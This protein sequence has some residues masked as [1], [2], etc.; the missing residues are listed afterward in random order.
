MKDLEMI[1]ENKFYLS[2]DDRQHYDQFFKDFI[3]GDRFQ[4]QGFI[5][6]ILTILFPG[7]EDN[8]E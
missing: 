8:I 6:R 5:N 4:Y 1:L 3:A 7:L 2:L